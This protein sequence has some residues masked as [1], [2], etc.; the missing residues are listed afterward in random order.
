MR[1]SILAIDC[2]ALVEAVRFG[3]GGVGVDLARFLWE[4]DL[5][6]R[7]GRPKS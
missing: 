7:I 2:V 5:R 3:N 4:V 6:F 1:L